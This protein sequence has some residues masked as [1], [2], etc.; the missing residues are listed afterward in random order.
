MDLN[1]VIDNEIFKG[2]S[3]FELISI[4]DHLGN[5]DYGHYYSYIKLNEDWVKFDDI[6]VENKGELDMI[7]SKVCVLLYKRQG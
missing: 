3:K 5:I 1:E 6:I 4:I 2:S 7:S